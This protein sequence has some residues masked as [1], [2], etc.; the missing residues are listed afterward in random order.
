[1]WRPCRLLRLPQTF[2]S[3]AKKVLLPGSTPSSGRLID[4]RVNV[5]IL[6]VPL[7]DENLSRARLVRHTAESDSIT[8]GRNGQFPDR[9]GTRFPWLEPARFHLDEIE[10]VV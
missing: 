1:M 9:V 3:Y 4:V 6:P 8:G 2:G 5:R 10:G 7:I